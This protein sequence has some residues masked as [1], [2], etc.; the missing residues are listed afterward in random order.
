[1]A[2]KER[3]K[4]L[5][6]YQRFQ[7]MF[8]LLIIFMRQKRKKAFGQ[9]RFR[10]E[11]VITVLWLTRRKREREDR[12]KNNWKKKRPGYGYDLDEVLGK[13]KNWY[14]FRL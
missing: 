12:D 3:M 10:L 13:F 8:F 2:Q 11:N 14:R 6:I 1:M 5:F 9:D 7:I 4:V